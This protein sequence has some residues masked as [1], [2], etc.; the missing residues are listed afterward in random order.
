VD[1]SKLGD[2]TQGR[3][4]LPIMKMV[5]PAALA[6]STIVLGGCAAAVGVTGS[7]LL[8]GGGTP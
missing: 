5:W 8:A 3:R 2:E 7:G 1:V 4:A 6:A